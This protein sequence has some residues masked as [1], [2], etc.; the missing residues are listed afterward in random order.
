[1]YQAHHQSLITMFG[2]TQAEY[3]AYFASLPQH[4]TES[5]HL[6]MDHDLAVSLIHKNRASKS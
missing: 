4:R 1:V 3:L 5:V 2:E 6:E